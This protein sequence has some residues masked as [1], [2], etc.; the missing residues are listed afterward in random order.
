MQMGS[1]VYD[2]VGELISYIIGIAFLLQ[3]LHIRKKNINKH[4]NP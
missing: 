4:V 2:T 1:I 3:V